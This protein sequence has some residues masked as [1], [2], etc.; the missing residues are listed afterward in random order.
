MLRIG[1]V[2][3]KVF[4]Q[5]VGFTRLAYLAKAYQLLVVDDDC[6]A[7]SPQQMLRAVISISH[8]L[9][10]SQK[11]SVPTCMIRGVAGSPPL[12]PSQILGKRRRA[13]TGGRQFSSTRWQRV[14]SWP[15]GM[16]HVAFACSS[17]PSS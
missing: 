3:R 6:P 4:K 8:R 10:N 16:G 15:N 1:A 5:R 12:P 7:L 14:H 2:P 13:R 9:G 11:M 17:E